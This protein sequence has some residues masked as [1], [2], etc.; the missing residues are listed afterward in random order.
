MIGRSRGTCSARVVPHAGGRRRGGGDLRWAGDGP[1]GGGGRSHPAPAT[2][3]ATTTESDSPLVAEAGT[4]R[5]QRCRSA[6]LA[7]ARCAKLR[8]PLDPA[9]PSGPTIRIALS[10]VAHTSS[11]RKHRGVLLLNPGGPGGSGLRM[12]TTNN[13]LPAK[14][15]GRYDW[16][17]F[18]PRGSAPVART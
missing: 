15:A 7:Q 12:S 8:V 17:G 4:L 18:D 3:S 10:R 16:I 11:D 1:G 9:D 5:W 13:S 2:T 14:V 6:G